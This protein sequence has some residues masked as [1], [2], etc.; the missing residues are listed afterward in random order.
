MVKV[1]KICGSADEARGTLIAAPKDFDLVAIDHDLPGVTGLEFSRQLLSQGITLPLVLLVSEKLGNLLNAA[2]NT[3]IEACLLKPTT[4]DQFSVLPTTLQKIARHHLDRLEREMAVEGLRNSLKRLKR[5]VEASTVPSFVIDNEHCVTDWNRACEALTGFSA[6]EILGTKDSWRA[7]YN[8]PRPT[9]ADLVV[10]GLIESELA[11]HSGDE[12]RKS[13][14][15]EGYE[16]EDYF[17]ALHNGGG[18]LYITA[19]PLKDCA[20]RVLGAIATLQNVTEIRRAVERLEQTSTWLTQIL[21]SSTVPT[22][23]IDNNHRLTHW[24]HACEMLTGIPAEQVINTGNQWCAFYP[25]ARPTMAD[26]IVDNVLES[27]IAK[28]YTSGYRRALLGNGFEAEGYFPHMGKEGCWIFFTSALLRS[29]SGE[30]VGAL[31]TLQDITDRRKAEH[32]LAESQRWLSQIIQGSA[33]PTF[34]LDREHR[35]REWN[36]ACENMTGFKAEQ[37]IGTC[38][39][40]KAFSAKQRPVLADFILDGVSKE[41]ISMQ[42]GDKFCL[43]LVGEGYEVEDFIPMQEAEGKWLFFTAS[44]LRDEAG[45]VIGAIETLQDVTRRRKA[46]DALR[47]SKERYREL[48]MTDD[49]TN[50]Y[51]ARYLHL[52][53]VEEINRAERYGRPLSLLMLDMDDFKSY[54]DSF[55]HLKGDLVLQRLADTIRRCIRKTDSAFRYG[56]EEFTVLLPESPQEEA[57]FIA[58]RIRQ[59]F[60]REIFSP[61]PETVV[62]K[63]VSIGV[64]QLV[65]GEMVNALLSRADQNLYRAKRSGKNR[66]DAGERNK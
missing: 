21:N 16:A 61:A 45:V 7:F 37:M 27:E 58:E 47:V 48:S 15:G 50:L 28:H 11:K 55:G 40:W 12:Y 44:P 19:A 64:A 66:V 62:S 9:M 17:P 52:R 4:V 25:Q 51:N 23:V 54:N 29:A 56:G 10:D 1:L 39:Q 59:E 34:V 6:K 33:V 30:I 3:G 22:F 8:F 5:I 36:I 31:E 60:L 13:P 35:I 65:S 41:E 42:Y 20:G 57:V 26:L 46:E 18:W 32:A 63:T 53:A 43:S 2:L 24:N 49:L 38:N 14:L